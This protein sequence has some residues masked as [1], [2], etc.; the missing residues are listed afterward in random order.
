MERSQGC[1]LSPL[2]FAVAIEHLALRILQDPE[3]RGVRSGD[4]ED[5]VGLYAHDLILFMDDMELTLSRAVGLI[6][7]FG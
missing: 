1:P 2:L 5:R 4:R 3:Y 7:Q 6:E